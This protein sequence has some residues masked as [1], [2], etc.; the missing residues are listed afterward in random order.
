MDQF[1]NSNE[2]QAMIN[3][4]AVKRLNEHIARGDLVVL[5]SATPNQVTGPIA[6]FFK[7]N[8]VCGS[9]CV[10][11]NN[12]VTRGQ[13]QNTLLVG[14]A[15]EKLVSE[16]LVKRY[17]I[18]LEN[19]YAYG[20]HITDLPVL[21]MVGNPVA[22]NPTKKL[23]LIAIQKNWEILLEDKNAST[24]NPKKES[25]LLQELIFIANNALFPSITD[26]SVSDD[27]EERA[28]E[29]IRGLSKL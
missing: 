1:V 5:I 13:Y 24:E 21:N 29:T 2:F 11:K 28:V 16:I 27:N 22:V 17:N 15:K 25:S 4:T 9:K 6:Q 14:H 18:D 20:D 26:T 3:K 8:I 10:V 12:V 7:A 19:S 23:E